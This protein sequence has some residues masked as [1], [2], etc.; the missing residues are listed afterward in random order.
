MTSI[1]VLQKPTTLDVIQYANI[2]PSTLSKDETS[3]T[4]RIKII[5][6][7]TREK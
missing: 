3:K 7:R 1:T 5:E 6:A 4:A 2:I